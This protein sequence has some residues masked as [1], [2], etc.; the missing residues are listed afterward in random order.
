MEFVEFF[1][2]LQ[3]N[4]KLYHWTTN[5]FA[6]HNASDKLGISLLPLIDKFM[7]SYQ[8]RYGK[9]KNGSFNMSVKIYN[10]KEAV[11]FLKLAL[12]SLET[13]DYT[14]LPTEL[15]NIIDEIKSEIGNTLYLF[16]LN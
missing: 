16:T 15:T 11:E 2:K 3:H 12:K 8:G 7:E 10:D 6:R 1:F 4:L 13:I 9:I 5:S 14:E